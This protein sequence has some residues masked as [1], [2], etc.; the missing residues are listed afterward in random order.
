MEF[1]P[2]DQQV[3]LLVNATAKS[4]STCATHCHQTKRCQLYEDDIHTTGLVLPSRSS[5]YSCQS[6]MLLLKN[7]LAYGQP[8]SFCHDHQ[9]LRCLSSTC[10]CQV[11]TYY[12]GSVCLSQ[13]LAGSVCSSDTECRIDLNL[14]CALDGRCRC[15]YYAFR[16]HFFI[17]RP[18]FIFS[19]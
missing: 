13:K 10:Q 1:S 8:C 16:S 6:L 9:Y 17:Y 7:L 14:T 2:I 4:I 15:M 12:N 18:C 19:P 5:H 3:P 11:H